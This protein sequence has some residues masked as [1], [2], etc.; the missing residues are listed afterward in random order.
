MHRLPRQ[1][2]DGA[3]ASPRSSRA[4]SISSDRQSTAGSTSTIA[5]VY[6]PTAFHPPPAYVAVAAASQIVTDHQNATLLDELTPAEAENVPAESA[7]FSEEALALL[8]AFLDSL[9]YSVLATGRSPSL[10][11]VRP[12][13]QEVLKPR[14]AREA[15]KAAD[16]ELCG[17]LAGEEE[18]EEFPQGHGEKWNLEAVFKRTRLRIMVYTRLGEL[19]DEDEEHFLEEDDSYVIAGADDD[20]KDAGLVSWA[21]AIF[22]TSVIEFVA[23]QTL[24]VAGQAA[25]N[26]VRGKRRKTGD[27]GL[28]G[29]VHFEDL[30][31]V[32]VQDFDMEKVALN[33]AL[34]RLWRT[35]KKTLRAPITPI[36]ASARSSFAR[37]ASFSNGYYRRYSTGNAHDAPSAAALQ[38][39]PEVEHSECDIAANIPLPMGA[40]DVEEIEVPGL[41]ETY[42][43]EVETPAAAPEV[44]TKQRPMSWLA[45][46]GSGRQ[47]LRA[48]SSSMPS[49]KQMAQRQA[50]QP[51]VETSDTPPFQTPAEYASQREDYMAAGEQA[52]ETSQ[53]QGIEEE[54]DQFDEKDRE[55]VSSVI[56]ETGSLPGAASPPPA[57][58]YRP[59]SMLRDRSPRPLQLGR[60]ILANAK[61]A[62][63]NRTNRQPVENKVE[64]LPKKSKSAS[65]PCEEEERESKVVNSSPPSEGE[66]IGLAKTSD[67]AK[68]A[69]PSP[70]PAEVDDAQKEKRHTRRLSASPPVARYNAIQPAEG[71]VSKEQPSKDD[72]SKPAS[73]KE[74]SPH[75][76]T[77]SKGV[78]PLDSAKD[79]KAENGIANNARASRALRSQTV[80]TQ[81]SQTVP[82]GPPSVSALSSQT[83]DS[84]TSRKSHESSRSYNRSRAATSEY[85]VDRAALQR[86]SSISSAGTSILHTSR[87]SESSIPITTGNRR[88]TGGSRKSE[89]DRARDFDAAI[90]QADTVYYTL[91]PERMRE[92]EREKNRAAAEAQERSSHARSATA[93][94]I[95]VYP[96]VVH[97][98]SGSPQMMQRSNSSSHGSMNSRQGK[99]TISEDSQKESKAQRPS[100]IN[101]VG[102]VYTRNKYMPREP[103]VQTDPTFDLRDFLMSTTPSSSGKGV[104]PVDTAFSRTADNTSSTPTVTGP[105]G[106]LTKSSSRSG[107]TSI[108][109]G[110]SS[111][112]APRGDSASRKPKKSLE[113]R[114]PAGPTHIDN[115]LIDLIRQGPPGSDHRIPRTVAPFRDT[116]DS[117]QMELYTNVAPS[118]NSQ[119]TTNSRSGLLSHGS[120][121]QPAYSSEPSTLSG[122][123]SDQG[124][125]ITKTRPKKRI[126]P[127]AIPDDD[128]LEEEFGEDDDELTALPGSANGPL[129]NTVSP[130]SA[131]A[132]VTTSVT[133]TA[134]PVT[135]NNAVTKT[136]APAPAPTTRPRTGTSDLA[137][138]LSSEPPGPV[139]S[140]SPVQPFMLS[141]S[142]LK[143]IKSGGAATAA[144]AN[145]IRS[146]SNSGSKASS[147][148]GGGAPHRFSATTTTTTITA[149][150]SHLGTSG[151]SGSFGTAKRSNTM[152]QSGARDARMDRNEE[153]GG[154][155]EMADF[156]KNS[157]PPPG[158]DEKPLPFIKFGK[159]GNPIEPGVEK[160]SS[161]RSLRFWKR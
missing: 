134:P 13:V 92:V 141:D 142:T 150:N 125:M 105:K 102:N 127:Y 5:A 160:K 54:K 97:S 16:E 103:R 139:A 110:S 28:N 94:Q 83:R 29:V 137:D 153:R 111:S 73:A 39:V 19:E 78:P 72:S 107:K 130:P 45:A 120:T 11:S 1:Q 124:P 31:R 112:P 147:L 108:S 132:G 75:S 99:S 9:L 115:D 155:S 101:Q 20:S 14:L 34:G 41:A 40:N 33:S 114:S 128:E 118:V 30:D 129:T 65:P 117:E 80:S 43:D 90:A 84:S 157:G 138:F 60:D 156:L 52:A 122:S 149:G 85:G 76:S 50:F 148:I 18:D 7:R 71:S 35:W 79:E 74:E 81:A 152:R 123:M 44:P 143:A 48:R 77:S 37:S 89:D 106:F 62:D 2:D 32:I 154:L 91:T 8:N 53:M 55:D 27:S 38:D 131:M 121:V 61:P 159:D 140:S 12:A 56:A 109:E 24:I 22:L 151:S 49:L 4:P 87:G 116:M 70:L 57:P 82:T 161:G 136:A 119:N 17:L 36:S 93:T 3:L 67:V 145:G 58:T 66:V 25:F 26:R 46:P 68:P 51:S 59:R 15:I 42:E 69:P 88:Q 6:V 95:T 158:M 98:G 144:S 133:S 63:A 86:V 113:P 47:L 100:P 21:A 96:R 23:E 146:S 135:S 64:I 126:D 10:T 104:T